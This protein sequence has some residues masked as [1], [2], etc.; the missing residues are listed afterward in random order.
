MPPDA[1]KEEDECLDGYDFVG[2]QE[3]GPGKC[4]LDSKA[5]LFDQILFFNPKIGFDLVFL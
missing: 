1:D 5:V 2:V 3:P 4:L